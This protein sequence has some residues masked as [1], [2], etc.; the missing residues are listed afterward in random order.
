[1]N[2]SIGPKNPEFPIDGPG[3]SDGTN[4]INKLTQALVDDFMKPSEQ[5]LTVSKKE[6]PP[7]TTEEKVLGQNPGLVGDALK[8]FTEL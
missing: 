2:S 4:K 7:Q 8:K 6:L 1:M 5:E 3:G